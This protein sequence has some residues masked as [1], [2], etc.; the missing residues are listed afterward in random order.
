VSATS[1]LEQ[2]SLGR[3]IW[4]LFAGLVAFC[5]IPGL[6]PIAWPR[7]DVVSDYYQDWASARNWW[8]GLPVYIDHRLTIPRY[9][10]PVDPSCLR[11][12]FDA[13]PPSSIL[14][15][16][17]W[18]LLAYRE[19]LLAWNLLSLALLLVSLEIVRRSL[20]RPLTLEL[21]ST[22]VIFLLLSRPLLMQFFH[23]QWNLILVFLLTASWAAERSGRPSWS[24]VFLGAATAIK[25]FP[26]F[27]FLYFLVRRQWTT[28]FAGIVAFGTL[29]ALTAALL[30]PE[31][32]WVYFHDVLPRLA[33]DRSSWYNASLV[34]FWTRLFDPATAIQHVLPLWRS[35]TAL[36]VAVLVSVLAVIT[37]VARVVRSAATRAA[38]DHAFGLAVTGMLL[39]CPITWDHSFVLL[40]FPISMVLYD[41]PPSEI[42]KL[43]LIVSLA[44]IWFG[45]QRLVC[46]LGIP[47]GSLAGFA[48]PVHALT[49]L[50]Y[51]C[52]ALVTLFVIEA[53]RVR[54]AGPDLEVARS[55]S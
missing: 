17:P 53:V 55:I 36:R 5:Q 1:S 21:V 4:L 15:M 3:V 25:L 23:G 10:G 14:V 28:L 35:G 22:A 12:E 24:G 29:T 54:T 45:G 33:T 51:P 31:T 52:Y 13:H 18:A 39:V 49:V 38:L 7:R 6:V 48:S 32:F 37:T 34:G 44:A 50:A 2:Q 9:I 40:L 19:A 8:N 47:G 27:L 41:P 11:V 26:G 16:I 46:A 20:G 43:L 42:A 30:G